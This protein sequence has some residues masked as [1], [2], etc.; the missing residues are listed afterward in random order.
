HLATMYPD[1]RKHTAIIVL[2]TLLHRLD[3]APKIA[4]LIADE[5][6]L[7]NTG[8]KRLIA[9]ITHHEA[10]QVIDHTDSL[11]VHRFWYPIGESGVDAILLGLADYLAT[12][13][14]ELDQDAWLFQVERALMLLFAFYEQHDEI[15]SPQPFINGND[16]METLNLDGG[17]IIGELL[18][19]LREAQ[20]VGEVT[21]R[22]EAFEAARVYMQ[23]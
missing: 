13:G 21:S 17:R 10:S 8:K 11:A 18:A 1:D 2:A 3:D 23:Q 15:V 16:L 5:L 12:Y 20:V 6:H 19:T 14:N 9:M 7:S 22:D 4:G